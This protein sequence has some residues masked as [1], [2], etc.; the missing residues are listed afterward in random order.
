MSLR[1]RVKKL[2]ASRRLASKR[3][4]FIVAESK[5]SEDEQVAKIK[6]SANT[7]DSNLLIT[8]FKLYD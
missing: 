6:L 3:T 2:E 5:E 7:D 4:Y 1:M 8:V